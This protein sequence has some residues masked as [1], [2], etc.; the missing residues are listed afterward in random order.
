MTKQE[1][2]LE[3]AV[4]CL[5]S[6]RSASDPEYRTALVELVLWWADEAERAGVNRDK[7]AKRASVEQ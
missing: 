5:Q 1:E 3:Q 4:F 6:A 7:D 2:F